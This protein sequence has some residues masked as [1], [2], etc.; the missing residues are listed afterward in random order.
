[1]I[2]AFRIARRLLRDTRG[3]TSL[4][5]VILIVCVGLPTALALAAVLPRIIESYNQQR[6]LL[7]LPYP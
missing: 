4:E 6:S 3:A 7:Q 1:M 2:D 5:Y